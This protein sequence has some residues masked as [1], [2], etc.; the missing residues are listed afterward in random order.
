VIVV[1]GASSSVAQSVLVKLVELDDVVAT[2]YKTEISFSSCK[3]RKVKLNLLDLEAVTEFSKSL[4]SEK[5]LTFINFSSLSVDKLF[6]NMA[7]NDWLNLYTVN[8]LSSV[9]ALQ[10]LL[11][12]MI[13]ER[14]GKV[15]LISSYVAEHGSVGTS[16]YGAT[17]AALTGLCRTLSQEYGRYGIST[18]ILQLG[19]LNVGLIDTVPEERKKQLLNRIPQRAFGDT[20]DVFESIKYLIQSNYVNGATLKVDGGIA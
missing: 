13:A 9:S 11:K 4:T 5:N 18:N 14:W 15:I 6:L 16:G 2:Y 20:N 8:V 7:Q 3:L 12:P 10:V 1:V 19:Y 17:K